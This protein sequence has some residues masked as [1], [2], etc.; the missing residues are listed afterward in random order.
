MLYTATKKKDSK[1][2]HSGTFD[3]K[4]LT[5]EYRSHIVLMPFEKFLIDRDI[6]SDIKD[7]KGAA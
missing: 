5:A 4:Q 6:P 1:C 3:R 2:C 7:K